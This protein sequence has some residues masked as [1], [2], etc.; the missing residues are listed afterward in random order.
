MNKGS[1]ISHTCTRYISPVPAIT[2]AARTASQPGVVN[3]NASAPTSSTSNARQSALRPLAT[4]IAF[5]PMASAPARRIG[6]SGAWSVMGRI[7]PPPEIQLSPLP[8]TRFRA[9]AT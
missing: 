3:L 8:S 4:G 7:S 9:A 5:A 1:L 2:K 6:K